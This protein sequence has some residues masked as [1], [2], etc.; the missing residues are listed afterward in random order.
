MKWLKPGLV[1]LFV[2]FHL[3]LV[4]DQKAPAGTIVIKFFGILGPVTGS[5]DTAGTVGIEVTGSK[6]ASPVI[7]SKTVSPVIELRSSNQAIA[8]VPPTVT[9][10]QGNAVFVVK[11]GS[12]TSPTE[13]TITAQVGTSS[14]RATLQILPPKLSGV[15]CDQPANVI[16]QK[17]L[18]CWAWLD[19]L[20]AE[21]ITVALSSGLP[22]A[23]VPSN[24][25]I[26]K[27]ARKET[28]QVKAEPIAQSASVQVSA[29][30]AGVTKSISVT[31]L[32]VALES[33][34]IS[35]STVVGGND[36]TL[37]VKLT[38]PPPQSGL[39]VK[40]SQQPTGYMYFNT[41]LV[42]M[43]MTAQFYSFP[44]RPAGVSSP[45]SVTITA[46]SNL[47][48]AGD[49]RQATLQIMPATL[50]SINISPDHFSNVPLGGQQAKVTIWLNGYEPQND[51]MDIQY[52]GDT[53]ITGPS[54]VPFKYLSTTDFTVTV[55][56]CSVQPTCT[57][58]VKARYHGTEKQTSATVTH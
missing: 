29:T 26:P 57:V 24:A 22:A 11:T 35:P 50:Q 53:Q 10:T 54:P 32:P 20:A 46:S 44:I 5:Q 18:K 13:V 16:P 6:I 36:T 9:P 40:F 55:S 8:A 58:F 15:G 7:G 28:F 47:L 25:T 4:A 3:P 33:L 34:T 23:T 48:T 27:D 52:S 42:S 38:A 49:A 21:A 19:G 39:V 43:T 45:T 56:P 12:V 17:P 41:L 14:K 2:F 30:Y 51:T 37:A 31:V 1:L